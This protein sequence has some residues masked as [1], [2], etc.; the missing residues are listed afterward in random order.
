MEWTDIGMSAET[1]EI[2]SAKEKEKGEKRRT[3]SCNNKIVERMDRDRPELGNEGSDT[4]MING[5][6]GGVDNSA[7]IG[8]CESLR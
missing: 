2:R 5:S 4:D 7:T 8:K 3:I 6:D 1:S